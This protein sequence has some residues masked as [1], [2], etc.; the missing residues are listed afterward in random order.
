MTSRR[1]NGM[2]SFVM[3]ADNPTR[4]SDMLRYSRHEFVTYFLQHEGR[5]G[6]RAI[7]R[8]PHR[9][10][11][12]RAARC[13]HARYLH[14][15]RGLLLALGG[16]WLF[17]SAHLGRALFAVGSI[18]GV[19]ALSGASLYGAGAA[20]QVHALAEACFPAAFV[21]LAPAFPAGRE[22]LIKPV[23]AVAAWLSLVLGVPYVLTTEE[24]TKSEAGSDIGRYVIRIMG[25]S[26][27]LSPSPP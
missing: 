19:Y 6:R 14:T 4:D 24:E 23:G 16:L 15:A 3:P 7:D 2:P 20:F 9:V 22:K 21:Y 12:R 5:G 1:T 13:R 25:R 26:S 11:T 17:P 10:P 18:G 8:R 27:F